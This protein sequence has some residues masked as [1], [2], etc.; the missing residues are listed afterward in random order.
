M[1]I[2]LLLF[3]VAIISYIIWLSSTG[4]SRASEMWGCGWSPGV[5]GAT[6]NAIASSLPEL[7]TTVVFLVILG[8]SDGFVSGI[9]T[10]AGSSVFNAFVIPGVMILTVFVKN[11]KSLKDHDR[12]LVL[13]D[14][15]WLLTVQ[16]LI[17][18][19]ILTGLFSFWHGALLMIIYGLYIFMLYRNNKKSEEE[20]CHFTPE[21]KRSLNTKFVLGIIGVGVGCFFLVEICVKLGNE[22]NLGVPIIALVIAAA[23][24]S[25][26]DTFLSVR[27]ARQGKTDDAISNAFGSNIFDLCIAIGLPLF[28]YGLLK[29][30]IVLGESVVDSLSTIWLVL[31]GMTIISILVMYF[32]RTLNILQS[33]IFISFYFVFVGLVIFLE[34]PN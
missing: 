29:G 17:Y 1:T 22:F 33:I 9:S 7:F 3:G 13:R 14:G 27:D 32:S 18:C 19:I 15:L 5:R 21:T 23:A 28:I 16:T 4:I 34:F 8:D 30:D 6:I 25:V 26:P 12:S 24:T 10:V 11:R 2:L 20:D 31:M